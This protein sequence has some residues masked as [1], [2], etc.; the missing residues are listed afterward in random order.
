MRPWKRLASNPTIESRWLKVTADACELPN[1]AVVEPYFVIHEP[2]WV[3]ILA[4]N[5]KREVLVVRQYRYA[6]DAVCA[7]LPGGA[8]ES[9]ESPLAAAKR[10]LL[11]ETGYAAGTW[12]YVGALFAN[13]ARQTNRVHLFVAEDLS[14]VGSQTLDASEDIEFK[15]LSVAGIQRA[16]EEGQFSQ[17]LHVASY[18]RGTVFL[19]AAGAA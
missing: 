2:E 14:L 13:P 11:E 4:I 19:Q 7:E 12:S 10:E 1:G 8:A 3:H 6:A 16:I 15:F 18:Y 5:A 17:A 9:S